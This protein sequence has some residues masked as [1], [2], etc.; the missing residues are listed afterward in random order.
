M[1][2][3]MLVLGLGGA[4]L[5]APIACKKDEVATEAKA[6]AAAKKEAPAAVPQNAVEQ[7]AAAPQTTEKQ[8]PTA[9]PAVAAEAPEKPV[10]AEA[11]TTK[12]VEAKPAAG[13]PTPA[14]APSAPAATA[15]TAA[16]ASAA[17]S[18]ARGPPAPHRP[19]AQRRAGGPRIARAWCGTRE[20]ASG[21][22]MRV[23]DGA[24]RRS[25]AAARPR[26][27]RSAFVRLFFVLSVDGGR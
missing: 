15:E 8:P 13:Q 5:F 23:S 11:A 24:I 21:G 27:R 26:P 3:R 25:R 1:L 18:R 2:K 14:K 16:A 10:V 22:A 17:A 20:A 6:E 19:C 9:Q 7:P 4:F 12:T